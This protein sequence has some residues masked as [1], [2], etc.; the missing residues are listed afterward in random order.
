MHAF[1]RNDKEKFGA[2]VLSITKLYNHLN[3]LSMDKIFYLRNFFANKKSGNKKPRK[4]H[5]VRF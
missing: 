4:K 5:I 3:L 1:L 2:N